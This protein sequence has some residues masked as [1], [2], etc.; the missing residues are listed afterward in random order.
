LDTD[1]INDAIFH[2]IEGILQRRPSGGACRRV[3]IMAGMQFFSPTAILRSRNGKTRERNDHQM[4][5]WPN[6]PVRDSVDYV[7]MNDRVP[8]TE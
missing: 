5:D 4:H 1:G 2:L 3:I 6:T 7:W 8:Y